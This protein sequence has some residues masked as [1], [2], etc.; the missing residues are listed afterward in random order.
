MS[1]IKISNV[2]TLV[3]RDTLYPYSRIF[4]RFQVTH[5][6]V[7][8]VRPDII[9]WQEIASELHQDTEVKKA[10]KETISLIEKTFFLINYPHS[11]RDNLTQM[12]IGARKD[13]FTH[14]VDYSYLWKGEKEELTIVI[15]AAFLKEEKDSVVLVVTGHPSFLLVDE[16]VQLLSKAVANAILK[17]K[18][19]HE[20]KVIKIKDI[21]VSL[22]SNIFGRKYLLVNL[23]ESIKNALAIVNNKS[24]F[25]SLL[26]SKAN[27]KEVEALVSK[28][29]GFQ[30]IA[31]TFVLIPGDRTLTE[32]VE[33]W[34]GLGLTL[35]DYKSFLSFLANY[36][37]I[38]ADGND[39]QKLREPIELLP[40]ENYLV[41]IEKNFTAINE[42]I[43]GRT[44]P[45]SFI[46][47]IAEMFSNNPVVDLTLKLY[48]RFSSNKAF[49]FLVQWLK[50]PAM[51]SSSNDVKLVMAALMALKA[52]CMFYP[53][54][55]DAIV[56]LI[57]SYKNGI[58]SNKNTTMLP[59][60][61]K[62]QIDPKDSDLLE[63]IH[64]SHQL[65]M[66]SI[67]EDHPYF[68]LETNTNGETF[69][70]LPASDHC[71]PVWEGVLAESV[72]E[73]GNT[74]NNSEHQ[75]L[76]ENKNTDISEQAIA[77]E[78]KQ[79]ET[80]KFAVLMTRINSPCYAE[81]IQSQ[82]KSSD[83]LNNDNNGPKM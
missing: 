9:T 82:R 24:I 46:T 45:A 18:S 6:V 12:V 65:T 19:D 48:V 73:F 54:L 2:N 7:E 36:E 13:K 51:I 62:Q 28:I 27:E 31:N 32:L 8:T 68:K 66:L 55:D 39:N 33:S 20:G 10:A 83:N 26:S 11:G 74:N 71:F 23:N 15:G 58:I 53:M 21:I 47:S 56:D 16:F 17:L 4:P 34:R 72:L 37:K 44:K 67:G 64:A 75:A 3:T 59:P 60:L 22:D 40:I 77:R 25:P 80:V 76:P 29:P 79:E 63:K 38:A 5:E 42:K 50:N 41:W 43:I 49:Q 69:V 57:I 1:R 78:K 14:I 61:I 70:T 52:H 30:N 81:Q 35:G